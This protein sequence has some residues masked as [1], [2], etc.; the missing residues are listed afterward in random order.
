[1][2][3]TKDWL[4]RPLADIVAAL[5]ENRVR[6]ADLLDEAGERH[7][8]H[9]GT[10]DAYRVW[11]R[12]GAQRMAAEADARFDAGRDMGLLQGIPISVKDL[13]GVKGFQTFAGS[14]RALPVVWETEGP[15]VAVLRRE[16][17]IF[18]GKTHMVEFAFG[19][20]GTNANWP[21]PRNP[22]DAI[23]HRVPGGSSSGAGVSLA[24]GS[25]VIALGSDTAGSVRI[26]A[27]VTGVV[28]FKPSA[29]RWSTEGLVPLSPT[30]DVPGV[31]TR[32]VADAAI[33]ITVIESGLRGAPEITVPK[34]IDPTDVVIGRMDAYFWQDCSPG[35]VEQVER[36]LNDL[37]S[38]GVRVV[39]ADLPGVEEAFALFRDGGLAASEFREFLHA[40]L[41]GWI[42]GLDPNVAQRMG[43]GP[44]FGSAAFERRRLRFAELAAAA[45]DAFVDVGVIASPTVPLSAPNIEAVAQGDAYAAAN[46]RMLRNTCIANLL[47]LCALTVPVGLDALGLP[48]G[49]QLFAKAGDESRLIEIGLVVESILGAPAP[50]LGEPDLIS[51]H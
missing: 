20:V 21:V 30:F 22:W 14:P 13:F 8:R 41:P 51:A 44:P 29:G 11:D 15:I 31:L 35:V 50:R 48:V 4:D 40:E 17:A 27:S 16:G 25:V 12:R 23:K 42:D 46:I 19:G 10:L 5:R 34:A 38:K 7:D 18:T 6:S 2:T 43:L 39:K 26:P 28:G 9:T 24:E 45:K 49:L 1:M 37:V 47:G 32:S 33:A 36:A 3:M